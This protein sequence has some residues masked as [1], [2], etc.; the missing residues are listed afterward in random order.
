MVIN[1]THSKKAINFVMNYPS[2]LQHNTQTTQGVVKYDLMLMKTS[3]ISFLDNSCRGCVR[4]GSKKHGDGKG[5][6]NSR[7]S[8]GQTTG[9]HGR[10]AEKSSGICRSKGN[11]QT[12]QHYKVFEWFC[13]FFFLLITLLY[14]LH[15]I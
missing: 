1:K 4:C 12:Q 6:G 10:T 5:Y 2:F 11:K 3:L 15:L 13:P 7:K 8:F 9:D 14:Y